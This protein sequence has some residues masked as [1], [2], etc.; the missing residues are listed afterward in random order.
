MKRL[1]AG[2]VHAVKGGIS[3]SGGPLRERAEKGCVARLRQRERGVRVLRACALSAIRENTGEEAL[4][5]LLWDVMEQY[6]GCAFRTAKGLGFTYAI[7]GNEMF[8]DRKDKSITRASVNL[9]ACTA[10]RLQ[11][12]CG[13]VRGPKKLGTFGASYL[14]PVFIRL[15]LILAPKQIALPLDALAEPREG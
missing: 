3:W 7:R 11:R 4:L 8:V 12:E 9:A 1:R 15:G 10:L 2:S 14:Y 13:A 5:E 6:A